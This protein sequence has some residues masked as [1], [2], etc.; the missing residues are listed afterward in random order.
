MSAVTLELRLKGFRLPSF[1]SHYAG[2][3]EQAAR[4]GWSHVGY[5]DE[6]AAVEAADRAERRVAR[7]SPAINRRGRCN[8]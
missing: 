7:L 5:L 4:G 8:V 3:A 2:L 6:L 1:V